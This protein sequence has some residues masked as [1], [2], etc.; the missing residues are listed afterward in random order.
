[1]A[2]KR[3][4]QITPEA[5][6]EKSIRNDRVLKALFKIMLDQEN[7]LRA[8]EGRPATSAADTR[9]ELKALFTA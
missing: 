4:N 7:R 1:M 8:F 2:S 6:F 3:L 5:E 9:A